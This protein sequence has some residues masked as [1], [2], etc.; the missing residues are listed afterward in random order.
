MKKII[1]ILVIFSSCQRNLIPFNPRQTERYELLT[2]RVVK[3][4]RYQKKPVKWIITT[5][6][7]KRLIAPGYLLSDSITFYYKK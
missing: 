7:G 5:S 3:Q 1:L 4:Q 6:T 2:E